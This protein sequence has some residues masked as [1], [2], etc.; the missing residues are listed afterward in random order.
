MLLAEH[1]EFPDVDAQLCDV[2]SPE[3]FLKALAAMN[4]GTYKRV[5]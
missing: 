3:A 5:E 2:I 4:G 1:A